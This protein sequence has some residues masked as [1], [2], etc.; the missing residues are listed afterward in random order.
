MMV[1]VWPHSQRDT[2]A[3]TKPVRITGGKRLKDHPM[4][5]AN[6]FQAPGRFAQRYSNQTHTRTC[7]VEGCSR[8]TQQVSG[9]CGTCTARLRRFGHPLQTLPTSYDLDTAVRRMETQRA[10]LKLL[11]VAAL[12]RRWQEMVTECRGQA[13]PSYRTSGRFTHNKWDTDASRII[14]DMGEGLSFT[15]AFDLIGALHLIAIERPGFFKSDEAFACSTVEVLRRA[16]NIGRFVTE[17][18]ESNGTI[19][20]SFR[21]EVPRNSRLATAKLLHMG[22]GVAA[23]ALA[24]LEAAKAEKAKATRGDFW[25]TVAALESAVSA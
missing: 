10:S 25:A 4:P 2:V 8:T 22:A 5:T 12:E 13:E 18:R 19:R 20:R 14:R 3:S 17:M 16:A 23:A 15:R 21:Q 7:I 24:K 9:R 11:D 1:S 6:R